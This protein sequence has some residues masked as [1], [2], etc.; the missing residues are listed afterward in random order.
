MKCGQMRSKENVLRRNQTS[1]GS[2][3][4]TTPYTHTQSLFSH[5][6]C[7]KTKAKSIKPQ[8]QFGI[9]EGTPISTGKKPNSQNKGQTFNCAKKKKPNKVR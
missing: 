3:V 1:V 4:Q 7:T 6:I 5:Q 8:N 2:Q 9:E